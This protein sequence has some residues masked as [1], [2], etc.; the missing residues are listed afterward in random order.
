MAF[1]SIT[2]ILNSKLS[3]IFGLKHVWGQIFKSVKYIFYIS[4]L[5]IHFTHFSMCV[6]RMPSSFWWGR[7][8][9]PIDNQRLHHFSTARLGEMMNHVYLQELQSGPSHVASSTHSI[10]GWVTPLWFLHN[11]DKGLYITK[12]SFIPCHPH[13]LFCQISF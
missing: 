1:A 4:Y 7:I 5:S 9:I 12:L 11:N 2:F 3:S 6:W 13:P 10:L 8:V